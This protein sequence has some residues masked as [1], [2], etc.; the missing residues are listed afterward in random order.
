VWLVAL[1]VDGDELMMFLLGAREG[2]CFING[3]QVASSS[4]I[5]GKLA[6]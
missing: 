6:A 3:S 5:N 4:L 1:L 2:G